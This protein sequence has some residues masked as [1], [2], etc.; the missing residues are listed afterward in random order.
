[1]ETSYLSQEEYHERRPKKA[2]RPSIDEVTVVSALLSSFALA[3]TAWVVPAYLFHSTRPDATLMRRIVD[4][5]SRFYGL[6]FFT[7]GGACFLLGCIFRRTNPLLL[8]LPSVVSMFFITAQAGTLDSSSHNL[9]PF[10]YLGDILVVPLT[11]LSALV[12][13]ILSRAIVGDDER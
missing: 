8:G 4:F 7:L 11:I 2:S 12:G 10:E 13:Q 3:V 9:I 1:M 6:C 5:Y